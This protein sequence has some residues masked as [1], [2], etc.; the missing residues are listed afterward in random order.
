MTELDFDELDKAVNSLM[1]NVDTTKRNPALDDPEVKVVALNPTED[2][3]SVDNEAAE[4]AKSTS[5][6]AEPVADTTS[7]VASSAEPAA[8]VAPSAPASLAVKRRGQFMDMI[9]P[10]SDMKSAPKPVR[11]EGVV[12]APAAA[13]DTS[14]DIAPASLP[15]TPASKAAPAAAEPSE[16]TPEPQ[17]SPFLPGAK[18]EKRPLG[19]TAGTG[20]PDP[21]EN[22][23]DT[24]VKLQTA[25]VI[26][27][28]VLPEELSSDVLAVESNDLTSKTEIEKP[29]E[30][31]VE[32]PQQ[33]APEPEAE[34]KPVETPAGGSISQQYTEAVST[35]D[36]TSGSIYDTA[37]YHQPIEAAKSTK[38]ASPLKWIILVIV[39][40]I[41]GGGA[42]VG[43][44]LLTH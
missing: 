14:A 36:Q 42:G 38:K 5:A 26:D 44:F 11:R 41:V 9:H 40:L 12:I 27:T 4:P 28:Q 39:L 35:G 16:P 25:P 2:A 33:T 20:A 23:E 17:T 7:V 3:A 30:A 8:A 32:I 34:Q 1:T 19:G 13:A 43:Y 24:A 21:I 22:A 18:P 6:N 31:S 29:A 10:S 37:N 15:D